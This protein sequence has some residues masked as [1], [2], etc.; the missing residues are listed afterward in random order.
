MS[1][2]EEKHFLMSDF[3]IFFTG[4]EG[5]SALVR[6]LDNFDQLAIIHQIENKGWEPFDRHDCGPM[7]LKD[8][9]Q[10]LE[11]IYGNEPLDIAYLNQIY[12]KTARLPLECFDKDKAVGFK[13]RFTPPKTGLLVTGKVPV[14]RKGI[15]ILFKKYQRHR[16]EKSMLDLLKKHNIIAFV[17]I[18]QDVLRWALSKYH[19]DGT[20]KRGHLQFELARG[21]IRREDI[22]RINVDCNRLEQLV[23]KCER[24]LRQKRTLM[25]KL[26]RLRVRTYP[27]LYEGFCNDKIRYFEG[28]FGHLEVPISREEIKDALRKGAYYQKV[29]SD[30]I[31]EY[32]INHEEVLERFRDRYVVWH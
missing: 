25:G 24:S 1:V 26:K 4:K 28:I 3:I 27:L 11:L 18:R 5:T 13:M 9:R 2:K 21:T 15:N 6:L 32:V 8:L 12:T 23:S 19:G 30:D 14:V 22:P 31:S 7:S 16:F 17:V 20:G 10:C 29:H